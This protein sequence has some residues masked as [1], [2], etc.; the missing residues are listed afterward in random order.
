MAVGATKDRQQAGTTTDVLNPIIS[1]IRKPGIPLSKPVAP[2]A[3]PVTSMSKPVTS[4][5]KPV[6]PSSNP[7]ESLS[8]A[9]KSS[10]ATAQ[11]SSSSSQLIYEDEPC[12]ICHDEMSNATRNVSLDCGH[13]FH[14]E[15]SFMKC[16]FYTH[17]QT[18]PAIC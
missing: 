12:V 8:E 2:I 1:S 5:P 13:K 4:M 11:S 9:S 6:V 18:L 17:T 7:S 16:I 3:K 15:V 10:H 14:H